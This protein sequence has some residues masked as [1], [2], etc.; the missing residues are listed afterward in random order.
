MINSLLEFILISWCFVINSIVFPC[1]SVSLL[2]GIRFTIFNV[3]P[4][5]LFFYF[6]SCIFSI[7]CL[8]SFCWLSFECGCHLCRNCMTR[9]VTR[10]VYSTWR[11]C[12]FLYVSIF[13]FKFIRIQMHS[14]KWIA[15]CL[16][17]HTNSLA[18]QTYPYDLFWMIDCTHLNAT[19]MASF[20]QNN[21]DSMTAVL[22][23]YL[24][25]VINCNLVIVCYLF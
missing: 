24:V 5:F 20:T 19:Q 22:L 7:E 8:P 13:F 9:F 25:K 23:I 14:F 17:I 11:V 3:F 16:G 21:S 6:S 2:F 18:S 15:S 10:S 4:H 1:I 12:S